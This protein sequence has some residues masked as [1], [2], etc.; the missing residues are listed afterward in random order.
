MKIFI[1]GSSGFIGSGLVRF[2]NESGHEVIRVL[3]KPQR[4][5]S[6]EK[7]VFYD[8]YSGVLDKRDFEGAD[9]F[10]HL[11]GLGIMRRWSPSVKMEIE[12]SRVI[13]T[14]FLSSVFSRLERPPGVFLCAS[15]TGFYGDR[16]QEVLN[17]QSGAGEG[18]LAR[19]AREW[20]DTANS[21]S[22]VTRVVNLRF[23]VVLAKDGGALGMMRIPFMLGLGAKVGDGKDY[24][25]WISRN[26]AVRAIEFIIGNNGI[27][28][29]VNIV[30]PAPVRNGDFTKCVASAL[31]RP[32]FVSLN[33]SV[34]KLV[35]GEMGEEVVMSSARV[36]PDRLIK[37]GF[38]F[39]D[40]DLKT[41]LRSELER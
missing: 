7:Q 41:F 25:S 28:G 26:D 11:A 27:A 33:K 16:G 32:A 23:G 38:Q 22:P 5:Q 40:S 12:R 14:G 10:I 15:A 18:F 6:P 20:E 29:P 19:V 2:F 37:T 17:E 31:R 36:L 24:L 3:R 1:S 9:A 39:D 21:A 8:P 34:L 13:S 35:L 30:S 4:I